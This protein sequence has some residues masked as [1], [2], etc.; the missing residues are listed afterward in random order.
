M[1]WRK[2]SGCSKI[3]NNLLTSLARNG[4]GEQWLSVGSL[5]ALCQ[6]CTVW[7][8]HL[9]SKRLLSMSMQ[10]ANYVNTCII[11]SKVATGER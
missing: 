3:I 6:Y 4:T 9:V 2:V 1:K 11:E 10:I 7:P 5:S 8:S